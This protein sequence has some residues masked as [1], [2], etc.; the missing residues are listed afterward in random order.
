MQN[1]ENDI[2]LQQRALHLIEQ[3]R[4][5][6][7]DAGLCA[8]HRRRPTDFTRERRLTFPVLMLWLLQKS[9]KSLQA[10]PHEF[11]WQLRPGLPAPPVRAP[12]PTPPPAQLPPPPSSP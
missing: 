8:R 5:R 7:V 10:H 3:L 4:Q 9:L 12:P 6:L 1:T 11:F 2:R